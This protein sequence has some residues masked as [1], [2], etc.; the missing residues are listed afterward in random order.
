MARQK[1]VH[2]VGFTRV[3]ESA[4]LLPLIK[5]VPRG[6]ILHSGRTLDAK[7]MR[8]SGRI[9]QLIRREAQGREVRQPRGGVYGQRWGIS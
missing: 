5:I 3:W 9:F 1:L 8:L 6:G 2:E 7:S 4:Q